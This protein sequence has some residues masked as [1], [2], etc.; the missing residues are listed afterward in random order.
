MK[1]ITIHSTIGLIAVAIGAWWIFSTLLQPL[2]NFA[3]G[4]K[5]P[6]EYIFA[7]TM[8]PLMAL[9]GI[10][11]AYF[12]LKLSKDNSGKNIK[13]IV[14]TLSVVSVFLFS[15]YARNAF[16]E[17]RT[18]DNILMLIA[19]LVIIPVYVFISKY[20][21]KKAGL[22]PVKG[23]FVGKGIILILAW[24]IWFVCSSVHMEFLMADGLP[25]DQ[26][27]LLGAIAFV[28]TILIPVI[29]YKLA[30]RAIKEKPHNHRFHSIADSARSE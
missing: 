20:W 24:E 5:E 6:F 21:M 11:M 18:A 30:V 1:K 27:M 25:H 4:E 14:G 7:F 22:Q 3:C 2:Y 9:P 19:T 12:G 16:E 13:M 10:F 28:G 29:F 15:A 26:E 23:E 17:S 8:F